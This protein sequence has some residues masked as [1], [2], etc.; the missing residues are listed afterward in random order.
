MNFDFCSH[1][2]INISETSMNKDFQGGE[3]GMRHKPKS[4]NNALTF[5]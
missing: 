2:L 3:M 4:E 1:T 5:T